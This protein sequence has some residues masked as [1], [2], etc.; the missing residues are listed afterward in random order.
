MGSRVT[1]LEDR[2]G[3]VFAFGC[4]LPASVLPAKG[5]WT[6]RRGRAMGRVGG[7]RCPR[8]QRGCASPDRRASTCKDSSPE[9]SLAAGPKDSPGKSKA[10]RYLPRSPLRIRFYE[11]ISEL[12]REHLVQPSQAQPGLTHEV[13]HHPG[14]PNATFRPAAHAFCAGPLFIC[15]WVTNFLILN[16]QL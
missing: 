13:T 14:G 11:L 10:R 15:M 3:L 5:A 9:S 7:A 12:G 2:K 1:L 4:A 16:P 6:F 8:G